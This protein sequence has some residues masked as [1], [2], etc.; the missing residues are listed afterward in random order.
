MTGTEVKVMCTLMKLRPHGMACYV[1]ELS[2]LWRQ[3]I[4]HIKLFDA[5]HTSCAISM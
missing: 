3:S 4:T 1:K 2:L 5:L